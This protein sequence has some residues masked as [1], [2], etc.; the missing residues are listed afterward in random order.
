VGIGQA[1]V[2]VTGLAVGV[3]LVACGGEGGRPI[4]ADDLPQVVLQR[5]DVEIGEMTESTAQP[6]SASAAYTHQFEV[7]AEDVEPSDIACITSGAALYDSMEQAEEAFEETLNAFNDLKADPEASG[8]GI[9]LDLVSV[10]EI[11]DR[12]VGFRL[13]SPTA[14]FCSDYENEPIDQH[15]VMFRQGNVLSS[16]SVVN[17]ESGASLDEAIELAEKQESRINQVLR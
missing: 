16:L 6:D 17:F 3:G 8:A 11:G 13:R 9:E 14:V 2:T 15:I 1:G 5:E 4:V 10:P 7:P 12:A